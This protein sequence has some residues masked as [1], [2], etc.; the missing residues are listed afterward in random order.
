MLHV[1]HVGQ[2][3]GLAPFVTVSQMV[4]VITSSKANS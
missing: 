1:G 4:R 3:A 2:L